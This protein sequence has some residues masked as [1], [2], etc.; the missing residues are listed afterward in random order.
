MSKEKDGKVLIFRQSWNFRFLIIIINVLLPILYFD[1]A[2]NQL[3]SPPKTVSTGETKALIFKIFKS[4]CWASRNIDIFFS[5]GSP[6]WNQ[7]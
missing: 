7:F 3:G 6:N 5:F 2:C 1:L 4:T